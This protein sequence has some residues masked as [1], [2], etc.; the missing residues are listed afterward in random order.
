MSLS[1]STT[2]I[3]ANGAKD[4][5][6]HHAYRPLIGQGVKQVQEERYNF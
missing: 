4:I 1:E 5:V 3:R 2:R 6:D